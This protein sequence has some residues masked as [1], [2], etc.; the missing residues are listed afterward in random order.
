MGDTSP[1]EVIANRRLLGQW[2][3]VARSYAAIAIRSGWRIAKIRCSQSVDSVTAV[4]Q[5]DGWVATGDIYVGMPLKG[6]GPA[7]QIFLETDYHVGAASTV[8]PNAFRPVTGVGN[9]CIAASRVR[10]QP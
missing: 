2:T 6:S 7:V 9:T 5:F 1:T 4:K 10:T 3:A 8:A